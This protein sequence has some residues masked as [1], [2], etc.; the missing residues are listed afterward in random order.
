MATITLD[1]NTI[2][3]GEALEVERQSGRDFAELLQRQTT[4]N[5]LVLLI[6]DLRTSDRPRSWH[7][8]LSLRISDSPFSTSPSD[9]DGASPTLND[10]PSETLP[11]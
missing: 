10:S 5:V 9:S 2:T 1:L 7:E 8:L 6:N 3:L 11:T 4:R